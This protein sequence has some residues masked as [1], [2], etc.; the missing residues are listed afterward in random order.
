MMSSCV[1]CG[2]PSSMDQPSTISSPV[3]VH[4]CAYGSCFSR[5]IPCLPT[6][7]PSWSSV[8]NAAV[9]PVHAWQV[10]R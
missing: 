4:P 9:V 6:A 8:G 10:W 5:G 7:S 2:C 3:S 1:T